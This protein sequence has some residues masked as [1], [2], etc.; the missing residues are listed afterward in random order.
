MEIFIKS[1]E[2]LAKQLFFSEISPHIERLYF[3]KIFFEHQQI[4]TTFLF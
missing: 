3:E 4:R 1:L 2:K